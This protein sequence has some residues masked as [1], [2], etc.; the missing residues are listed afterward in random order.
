MLRTEDRP[1]VAR[2]SKHIHAPVNPSKLL[3]EITNCS[4]CLSWQGRR[5]RLRRVEAQSHKAGSPTSVSR[6]PE[7]TGH[8]G[9]CSGPGLDVSKPNRPCQCV[10][11]WFHT[12]KCP[13]R[14]GD[15]LHSDLKGLISLTPRFLCTGE[16]HQ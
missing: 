11:H 10:S 4:S 5:S 13:K 14:R 6:A 1:T 7:E 9:V 2:E 3:A 16:I 15:Q 8:L 12:W